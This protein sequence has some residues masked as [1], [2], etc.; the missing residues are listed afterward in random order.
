[1]ADMQ[2]GYIKDQRHKESLPTVS[3]E[4]PLPKTCPEER[5]SS[6][7]FGYQESSRGMPREESRSL[8]RAPGRDFERLSPEEPVQSTKVFSESRR[9]PSLERN[10]AVSKQPSTWNA[11]KREALEGKVKEMQSRSSETLTKAEKQH[12]QQQ[13]GIRNEFHKKE[14]KNLLRVA[15]KAELKNLGDNVIAPLEG[16][17]NYI[18]K[19]TGESQKKS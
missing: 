6:S 14:D 1:M 15:A 11:E 5:S 7:A 12:D 17:A 18:K 8:S 3:Q 2:D 16:A 13:Q 10:T 9:D 19:L 4:R